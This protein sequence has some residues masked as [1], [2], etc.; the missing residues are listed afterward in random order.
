M[1]LT[2]PRVVQ[3][4]TPN[5]TPVAIQH[6]LLIAHMMEGGYAGSVNWLCRTE[7][8]A[9]AHLCMSEDGSEV[10]QLVPLG[11]KAWAQCAFNGRGISLEIPGFTAQGVADERLRAAA[12]IFAWASLAYAIP[13]VWAKNGRGRGICSHHDLGTAGGGHVDICGVGDATWRKF[14]NMVEDLHKELAKAPLPAFALHGAPNPHQIETPPDAPA[15]PSHGGAPRSEPGDVQT[16]PTP[17]GFPHGSVADLQWRLNRA[18]AKPPLKV[19]G[20]AGPLTRAA[21]AGFQSG[22]GLEANGAVGPR[23]WAA[24][25]AAAR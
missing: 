20:F 14:M 15:E 3:R 10:S 24:L 4:P 11:M 13:V 23:L 1:A 7:A 21:I 25:D 6:D 22:N 19:D 8:R 9:S 12:L 18:G 5:Y 16:H 17:S 2:M